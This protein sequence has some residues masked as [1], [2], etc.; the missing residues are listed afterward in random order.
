MVRMLFPWALLSCMSL[1][2]EGVT[3]IPFVVWVMWV[4]MGPV[5][6]LITC[7]WFRLPMRASLVL[8]T[9]VDAVGCSIL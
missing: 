4:A 8:W 9:D 3:S 5:F 6:M 2:A 7:V 1:S